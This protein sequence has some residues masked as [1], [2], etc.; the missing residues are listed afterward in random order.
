MDKLMVKGKTWQKNA[1]IML[2]SRLMDKGYDQFT[3]CF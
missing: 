2:L 3:I 1:V